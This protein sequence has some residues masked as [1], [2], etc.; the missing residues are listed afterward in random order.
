MLKFKKAIRQIFDA[1]DSHCLEI[2]QTMEKIF[3]KLL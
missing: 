2:E 1:A 3:K